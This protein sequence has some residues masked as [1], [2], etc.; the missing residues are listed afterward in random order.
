MKRLGYIAYL[1]ALLIG[2][3]VGAMLAVPALAQVGGG[4]PTYLI[5]PE[6]TSVFP[7]LLRVPGTYNSSDILLSGARGVI[8]TFNQTANVPTPSTVVNVQ[9]KDPA[10]TTLGTNTYVTVASTTAVTTAN[11]AAGTTQA[12]IIV[13]P[14]AQ[15]TGLPTGFVGISLPTPLR[16][17]VQMVIGGTGSSTAVVGCSTIP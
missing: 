2:L 1:C 14:G 16:M 4:Q 5:K 15:T 3:P 7:S 12:G 6:F 13:Y 11:A 9:I 10:S 8:C 17:R